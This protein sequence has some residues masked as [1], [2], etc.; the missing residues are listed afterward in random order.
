MSNYIAKE[1]ETIL[2]VVLNATGSVQNWDAVLNANNLTEWTPVISAG[3]SLVIPED[4]FKDLIPLASLQAYPV[5]NHSVNDVYAKISAIFAIMDDAK[6]VDVPVFSD[7]VVDDSEEYQANGGESIFDI[8][9]N[10]TGTLANLD[11]VLQ[12]N[13]FTTWTPGLNGG[14]LIKIPATVTKD[15]NALRQFENYPIANFS[16]NN[17]DAQIMAI[18][19]TLND[20]WILSTGFWNDLSVWKDSKTWID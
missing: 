10:A 7:I 3:Q 12:A 1:G 6:P 14:E 8:V 5:C 13:G 20:N 19:E 2:D 4:A 17:I 18:F 15:P 11:L 16:V 9:I